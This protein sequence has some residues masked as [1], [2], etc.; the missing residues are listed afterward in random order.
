V[1]ARTRLDAVLKTN[2]SCACQESISC[3]LVVQLYRLSHPGAYKLTVTILLA[4]PY[5]PV[6]VSLTMEVTDLADVT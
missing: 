4:Y 5:R 1:G 6:D 2:M 3:Y